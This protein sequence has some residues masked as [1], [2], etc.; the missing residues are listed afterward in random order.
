MDKTYSELLRDP[1]WQKRKT[2]IMQR[3][4][5]TCQKC[6]C[7]TKTLNVHHLHYLPNRNPWN[8]QMMTW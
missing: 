7:K 5:F 2:E 4:N 3:D 8:I 1:R 6:G